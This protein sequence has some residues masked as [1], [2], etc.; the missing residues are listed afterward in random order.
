[1]RPDVVLIASS[2]SMTRNDGDP[3][4][5]AART[6]GGGGG[7]SELVAHLPSRGA[8]L[9]PVQSHEEVWGPVLLEFAPQIGEDFRLAHAGRTLE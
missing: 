7:Q 2:W 6:T 4:A 1:L 9:Q 3:A 5:T 8:C